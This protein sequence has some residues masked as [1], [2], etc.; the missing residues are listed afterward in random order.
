MLFTSHSFVIFIILLFI[1]YY[2]IPKRYQWILL[3]TASYIFYFFAGMRYLIYILF[4]YTRSPSLAKAW[5][6]RTYPISIKMRCLCDFDTPL[7]DS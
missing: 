1:V 2:L 5:H 3:L 4:T 7:T 6:S